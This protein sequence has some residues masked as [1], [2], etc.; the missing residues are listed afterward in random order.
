MKNFRG[1]KGAA[2]LGIFA[3]LIL[4][5]ASY[6]IVISCA[7][8]EPGGNCPNADTIDYQYQPPPFRGTLTVV[9]LGDNMG[10]PNEMAGVEAY[11]Q[12]EQVGQSSC[13]GTIEE[14]EAISLPELGTMTYAEFLDFR[15][16]SLRGACLTDILEDFFTCVPVGALYA[17][18]L[19]IG[20]KQYNADGS[21]T[22]NVL[23]MS[24]KQKS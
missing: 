23:L 24:V 11:G 2:I 6:L 12:V 14:G 19:A 8:V 13:T 18:V 16:Q 20:A 1:K 3:L 9:W 10:D 4:G 21:V 22:L 17:D 5:A 7:S 15:F